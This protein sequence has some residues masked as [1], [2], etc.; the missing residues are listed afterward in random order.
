MKAA[1]IPIYMSYFFQNLPSES[2][3][4]TLPRLHWAPASFSPFGTAQLLQFVAT[5][6]DHGLGMLPLSESRTNLIRLK[7][8]S[9]L[10]RDVCE[11]TRRNYL[12]LKVPL[13]KT[14]FRY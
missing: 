10:Y 9:Q 14:F 8:D 2:I 11:S 13:K 6:E 3:P 12:P 1:T 4:N 5:F 7:R